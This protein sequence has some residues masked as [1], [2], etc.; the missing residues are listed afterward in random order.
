MNSTDKKLIEAIYSDKDKFEAANDFAE[1]WKD[2]CRINEVVC[3]VLGDKFRK[4][5]PE[6]EWQLSKLHGIDAY[7]WSSNFDDA[8][9]YYF[10]DKGSQ[11]VG[12]VAP[13]GKKFTKARQEE[14]ANIVRK[15]KNKEENKVSCTELWVYC[16]IKDSPTLFDDLLNALEILF[17]AK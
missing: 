3:E 16:N 14:L 17:K 4:I 5:F 8:K 6:K 15:I 10:W 13:E 1:L 7:Y 11:Q 9:V 12:F 2:K